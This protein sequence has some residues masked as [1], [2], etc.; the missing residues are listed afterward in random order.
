MSLRKGKHP[1]F[2]VVKISEICLITEKIYFWIIDCLLKKS[3]NSILVLRKHFHERSLNEY[4]LEKIFEHSRDF[5]SHFRDFASIVSKSPTRVTP[6][7]NFRVYSTRVPSGTFPWASSGDVTA[8]RLG[9][10]SRQRLRSPVLPR[11]SQ[12]TQRTHDSDAA[13]FFRPRSAQSRF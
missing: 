8:R 7:R 4:T 3:W 2:I 1:F 6:T 5:E 10:I 11:S 9:S 12:L 13:S